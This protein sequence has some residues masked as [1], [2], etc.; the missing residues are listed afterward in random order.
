MVYLQ[1]SGEIMKLYIYFIINE[2][3]YPDKYK[4][5]NTRNTIVLCL[6]YSLYKRVL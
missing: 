4:C 3:I 1:L 2:H 6:S 5:K